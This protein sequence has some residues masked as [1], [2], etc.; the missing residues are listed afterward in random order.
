MDSGLPQGL[1]LAEST[2]NSTN[3][4]SAHL[5]MPKSKKYKNTHRH[6]STDES[7]SRPVTS[8]A[9]SPASRPAGPTR[10]RPRVVLGLEE[11]EIQSLL[12]TYRRHE[13]AKRR[14][15]AERARVPAR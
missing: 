5:D 10:T 3:R 13:H 12:H 4:T 9:T 15:V 14:H 11:T 8:W 1:L 2:P 6:H 7:D